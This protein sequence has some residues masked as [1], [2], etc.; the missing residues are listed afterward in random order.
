MY[1][2]IWGSGYYYPCMN[3]FFSILDFPVTM[4]FGIAENSKVLLAFRTIGELRKN[5]SD[6]LFVKY[7]FFDK[8]NGVLKK[9]NP[10]DALPLMAEAI[11]SVMG[12]LS[13]IKPFFVE[14]TTLQK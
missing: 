7:C 13:D 10:D 2:I 1:I 4:E 14:A 11:I 8:I 6:L 3:E 5:Y 12:R 9:T